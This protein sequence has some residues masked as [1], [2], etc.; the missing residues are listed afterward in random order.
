M[1]RKKL[2]EILETN[3]KAHGLTDDELVMLAKSQE[4]IQVTF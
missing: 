3:K 2:L 1:Y 4:K